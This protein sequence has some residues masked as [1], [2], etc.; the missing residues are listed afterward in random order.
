M[1]IN[2]FSEPRFRPLQEAF[3]ESF[4]GDP[5]DMQVELGAALAVYVD[6]RPVVDLW[7]GHLDAAR[8]R[9][10]EAD[11]IVCVQSVG[12]GILATLTHVLVERGLVDVDRPIADYWPEFAQNG[13]AELPLR[14]ALSHSLGLPA[15]QA[16]EPGMGYD[17]ERA[18]AGLAASRPDLRP[19]IDVSYHPYSYGFIV[20]EVLRR[21]SGQ[22]VDTLL[23]ET[24]AE[25][26]VV[27]FQYGVR[28]RDRTRTATFTHMRHGDNLAANRA[29]PPLEYG[30]VRVRSLD[31]LDHDEDYNSDAWRDAC[32]PAANGH[33][34]ARALARLYGGL[35]MGGELEGLRILSSETLDAAVVKQWGGHH[36]LIPMRANMALGYILNS[37]SFQ[38]GPNPDSF[39]HA[40]FGG[41]F[42]F[43]DRKLGV[44]FG[45]TPN[46]LWLG[47]ELNTGDRCDRLVKALFA[48]LDV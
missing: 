19:G 23:A 38:S 1:T 32:F 15:W 31:V 45:Y 10:W 24:V 18:T 33:T 21:A 40:G 4:E 42:G 34:N 27:D 14:W 44:G 43:A 41:A 7:G 3:V 29:I 16:P 8:N 26:W 20:G 37:P 28:P 36:L 11:S 9:A 39:G 35:A 5:D 13:K 30:D 25:P 17:W 12:K 47:E 22:S 48:C 46:K 2:G 6:G